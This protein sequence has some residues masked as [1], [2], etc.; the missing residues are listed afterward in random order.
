MEYE[1]VYTSKKGKNF[2]PWHEWVKSTQSQEDF[3]KYVETVNS[4]KTDDFLEYLFKSW[5]E[6]QYIVSHRIYDKTGKLISYDEF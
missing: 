1:H 5:V 6:D 3:D 4:G 2:L